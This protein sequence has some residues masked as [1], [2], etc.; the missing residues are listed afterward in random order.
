MAAIISPARP[1]SFRAF[2][3]ALSRLLLLLPRLA[4]AGYLDAARGVPDDR[5]RLARLS[6][7]YF[8]RGFELFLSQPEKKVLRVSPRRNG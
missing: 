6:I 4:L 8:D 1:S 5:R 2:S 7:S 3:L